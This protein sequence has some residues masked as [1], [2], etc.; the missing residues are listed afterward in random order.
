MS[1]TIRDERAPLAHAIGE[2]L[3][4]YISSEEHF[5]RV[6]PEHELLE[7][8]Q[9]EFQDDHI[10]LFASMFSHA[11]LTI[12]NSVLWLLISLAHLLIRASTI[13]RSR[14]AFPH[15]TFQSLVFQY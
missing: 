4:L 15:S 2:L 12:K 5:R 10:A 1:A 7:S 6:T 8:L 3:E 14:V 13:G 9:E 11:N